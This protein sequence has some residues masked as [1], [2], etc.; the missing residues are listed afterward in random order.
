MILNETEIK[1]LSKL[2]FEDADFSNVNS[3]L[4]VREG[5]ITYDD[6]MNGITLY[7]RPKDA[8][9]TVGG[10]KMSIADALFKFGFSREFTNS[11]GG[12]M[13][14]AGVYTVYNLKSSNEKATGYG[15]SIIKLKLLGGYKDFL[16]FS[17]QLAKQTYGNRWHITQQVQDIFPEKI[18]KK[19][20]S[21]IR[22]YMH[23]DNSS[24]HNMIKSSIPAVEI[25]HLLGEHEINSTKCRGL[26]YNG[27]HDGACCFIRDFSSA[28]PVAISMDNGRTWTT[29]LNQELLNR[30]NEEVDTHFQFGGNK[31]FKDVADKAINGYTI[32]WNKEGKVNYI[33]SNSNDTISDIWFDDGEN[34]EK[35]PNGIP[36]VNVKYGDYYLMIM[37][38]DGQYMVYDSDGFPQDCTINE[39]PEL[40]G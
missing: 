11:N 23:N 18:A 35:T 30:Y 17:E 9:A 10:E 24:F 6:V 19:I 40:I 27:G 12:N 1:D 31:K 36:Y 15:K 21:S 7:H 3:K 5:G 14:G 25:V 2:M 16:I 32:V 38:E 28:I 29:K 37:Y 33:P 20:L 13:Y 39:L 34:W 26:V 22:L 8:V 4:N